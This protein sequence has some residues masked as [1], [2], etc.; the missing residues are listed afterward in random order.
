MEHIF[1]NTTNFTEKSVSEKYPD[2]YNKLNEFIENRDISIVEKIW[3]YQNGIKNPPKCKNCGDNVKFIKFSKGYNKFCSRKCS[4]IFSHKNVLVKNKRVYKLLEYNKD[5]NIKKSMVEKANDTKSK[6]TQDKKDEI[7]KLRSETNIERYGFP[8]I[9]QVDSIKDKIKKKISIIMPEIR[10]KK[11]IDRLEKHGYKVIDMNK[12]DI[13]IYC[14]DCLKTPKI[15]RTLIN[16]RSRFGI[17]IC[18]ECNSI[19]GTSDFQ[20]GVLEFIKSNTEKEILESYRGFK[21]YEIDIYIP[22][23]KIGF[24]CNGLWWHSELYRNKEYHLEKRKFFEEK[25]I[26]IINIWEDDWKFKKNIVESRILYKLFGIESKIY[27]RKC[28]IRNVNTKESKIFLDNNHIQGNCISKY[29]IGLYYN[30]ELVSLISFGSLRKNLGKNSIE[31]NYELLRFCNKKNINIIGSFSK[32]LNFFE[33]KYNPKSI[34]SYCDKSYSSGK[35]YTSLKFS[36]EK[37]TSPNYWY[38][39]KD[40]GIRINRWN[41]RKDK[42]VK[43][44]FDNSKT[45]IEIMKSRNYY[46]IWDCGSYLFKKNYNE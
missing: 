35:S 21:K 2:F 42:L 3:L 41:F 13:T 46:R 8:I 29:R 10:N 37:E 17:K 27:A 31:D 23:D 45:E 43:E 5:V 20:R 16:Q 6:F 28:E 11:T 15:H 32:L 38:F 33:N 4:T 24:E 36:L 34:I 19:G 12:E 7:K 40:H 18:T 9:S 14:S 44:G 26:N 1:K 25:G 30:D 22:E 39:H